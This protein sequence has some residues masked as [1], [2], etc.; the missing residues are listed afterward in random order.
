MHTLEVIGTLLTSRNALVDSKIWDTLERWAGLSVPKDTN[1]SAG[2]S[3]AAVD[4]V[5]AVKADDPAEPTI[6]VAVPIDEQA[7]QA[8]REPKSVSMDSESAEAIDVNQLERQVFGVSP[9]EDG[10]ESG[11]KDMDE[12]SQDTQ[13]TAEEQ[14]PTREPGDDDVVKRLAGELLR[15]FSDLKVCSSR[16]AGRS[17]YR[18]AVKQAR[19]QSCRHADYQTNRLIH[20]RTDRQPGRQADNRIGRST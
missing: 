10:E 17:T 12:D 1:T 2:T 14:T 9:K 20:R 6:A 11:L 15:R 5:E 8:I 3:A 4:S 16:Q 18:Q 13:A 19:M 7:E